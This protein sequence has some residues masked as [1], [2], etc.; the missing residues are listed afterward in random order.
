MD[1]KKLQDILSQPFQ[2]ESWVS[3]FRE[4]FGVRHFLQNP[5]QILLPSNKKAE[6]AFELGSFNT[7]DDRII[8]LY[9]VK[10]K[11]EVWL[12]RNKVGL[13]ELLRSVYKYEVDG[14]LIVFEQQ[15]KWRLSFVSEI[16][17]I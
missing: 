8:G 17:S 7:S 14:A 9:L 6:A 2:P 5:L 3:L 13:R 4:I 1:R 11:P 12:E 16:R 15:D 10:V